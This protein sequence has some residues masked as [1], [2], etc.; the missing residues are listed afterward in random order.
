MCGIAGIHLKNPGFVKEH[1]GMENFANALLLGIEPRGRRATGF[2]AT[3]ARGRGTVVEKADMCASDFIQVRKELPR[4]TRTVLLHTRLD[5]KGDPKNN[6]NNHPVVCKSTFTVHNGSIYNDDEL[7][8]N[9]SLE[10]KA[11]VDSEVIPA[12]INKTG[13]DKAPDALTCFQGALAIATIDPIRFP[14]QLLLAKGEFSP[15][16]AVENDDFIV[17]ASERKAI[18]EAWALVLGTPPQWKRYDFFKEGEYWLI[19]EDQSITRGRYDVSSAWEERRRRREERR[20]TTT[21][22]QVTTPQRTYGWNG[23]PVGSDYDG[24]EHD[25]GRH[26]SG[27]VTGHRVEASWTY[28]KDL[29]GP[30]EELRKA[31]KGQVILMG[32]HSPADVHAAARGTVVW[33][34]CTGCQERVLKDH[35][36]ESMSWGK[37]C[38]DCYSVA[39]DIARQQSNPRNLLTEDERRKI[40]NWTKI[41]SMIHRKALS[42]VAEEVD[43]TEETI[44]WLVFRAPATFTAKHKNV[45]DLAA[46]LD[47][48]YQI[49][50][51]KLFAEHGIQDST[52]VA[53][54]VERGTQEVAP[55]KDPF[56]NCA[57]HYEVFRAS[58]G[59][60]RCAREFNKPESVFRSPQ[61]EKVICRVC[62]AKGRIQ[63]GKFRLGGLIFCNKHWKECHDGDGLKAVATS[64]DGTRYCH[65]CARGKKG[66]LFDGS[67][68][69]F[70]A[71]LSEIK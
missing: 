31:G 1:A 48:R 21:G 36:H 19:E 33:V 68:A 8:E 42:K 53:Q 28:R 46:E 7:F 41:E 18:E 64:T 70:G 49:E 14:D 66:L 3:K 25:F 47:D 51:A 26:G 15:L 2:V 37:M 38:N 62:K 58:E 54:T 5:T 69:N 10:R 35:V 61:P 12:L 71:E 63:R 56:V 30:V 43:L 34:R 32:E 17:W 9:Y 52:S 67:H 27:R 44:D 59:C 50:T 11:Q 40:N 29:K 23:W 13:L 57:K 6:E 55:R 16:V 20:G 60:S 39:I 4:G 24:D 22:V 45:N 65:Y